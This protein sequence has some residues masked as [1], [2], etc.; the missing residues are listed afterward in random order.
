MWMDA[1]EDE[2]SLVW[3]LLLASPIS[4]R[5]AMTNSSDR[6]VLRGMPDT[7]TVFRGVQAVD[8]QETVDAAMTGYSWT[9]SSKT[10]DFFAQRLLKAEDTP[11]IV[12]T[13]IK[14]ADVIA[15]L[16]ARGEQEILIQSNQLSEDSLAL[17]SMPARRRQ[18][19]D[20]VSLQDFFAE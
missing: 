2:S 6:R 1:E 15:Y 7:I 19:G 12:S 9:L 20:L 11:F 17:S 8:E 3:G 13:Q 16:S 4:N 5:Q 10:A 18:R 14:K